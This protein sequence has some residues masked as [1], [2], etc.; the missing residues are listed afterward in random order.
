MSDAAHRIVQVINNLP[1]ETQLHLETRIFL[2]KLRNDP[3]QFTL[4][5]FVGIRY[6]SIA[7]VV[8][9]IASYLIVLIQFQSIDTCDETQEGNSTI[10]A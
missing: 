5:G 3:V 10:I 6:C 9:V 8:G 2:N 1:I 4:A 7:S